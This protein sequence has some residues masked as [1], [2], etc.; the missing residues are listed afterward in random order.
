[1]FNEVLLCWCE[2]IPLRRQKR[3]YPVLQVDAPSSCDKAYNPARW[4]THN[5]PCLQAKWAISPTL[6]QLTANTSPQILPPM[7]REPNNTLIRLRIWDMNALGRTQGVQLFYI[8][9]KL[10]AKTTLP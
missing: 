10:Q 4:G 9:L 1:M 2:A 7:S 3:C 8:A 6:L 5:P